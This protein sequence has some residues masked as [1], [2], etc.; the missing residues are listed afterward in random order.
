MLYSLKYSSTNR[1]CNAKLFFQAKLEVPT[2][3]IFQLHNIKRDLK[4]VP[5]LEI[6]PASGGTL[7]KYI[8]RIQRILKQNA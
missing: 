5:A 7:E 8:D 6:N 1:F 4:K 3:K 2:K